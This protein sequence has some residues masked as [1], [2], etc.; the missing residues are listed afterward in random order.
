[1]EIFRD[2]YISIEPDRMAA[3]ADLIERSPP[4][5][6]TRDR[7]TEGKG[8][9]APALKPKPTYC[10][11]CS[12]QGRRPAALVILTQKDAGTFFVSNIVPLSKHQL[13]HGEYNA[14]LEE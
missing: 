1:M 7:A 14:I 9:S 4:A 12:Q 10:F 11:S 5:G 6:W 2:L 13:A 8:R 3:T